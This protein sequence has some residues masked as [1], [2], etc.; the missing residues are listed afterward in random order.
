MK[1][2]TVER[3]RE[4]DQ[5]LA[6]ALER[7][8]EER[9]EWVR[10]ACGEDTA[11]GEAVIRLLRFDEAAERHLGENVT[12]FAQPL[13]P[14]LRDQLAA[15]EEDLAPGTRVGRYRII[16]RIG[17]GGMG[18]VYLA[19]RADD[20]RQR[21]ALKLVKRGM[22][23]DEI[24]SRFRH[25]RQILAR[26]DH[27]NIARLLDGGA[28]EDGR[29]YLVVA[30]VEGEPIDAYCDARRLSVDERLGLFEHVCEA[31]RYAHASLV[32]HRDLKP[33]NIL[34]TESGEV[35]LLDFGIAKLLE[36]DDDA[37]A[38]LTRTGMHRLTPA[39]AAPEQIRGEPVTTA[40]DVYALGV[41]LHELLV[42]R[43]PSATPTRGDAIATIR[44]DRPSGTALTRGLETADLQRILGARSTTLARLRRHLSG[45]LD[46][47]LLTA[48][49][50]EPERRYSSA[51]ALLEDV[52]RHRAHLPIRARRDSLSYRAQAFVRRHRFGVS[53]GAGALV[54]LLGFAVAMTLQQRAT[55]RE[56][57]RARIEAA[58]ATQVAGF[59]EELFGTADPFADERL[60]TLRVRDILARG[61]ERV[62]SDLADQ[63]QV[64]AQLLHV[65]GRVYYAIGYFDE[66]ATNLR[67]SVSLREQ[68]VGVASLETA[69]SLFDLATVRSDQ[70]EVAEAVS[71]A[72]RALAIREALLPPDHADVAA[73]RTQLA[74]DLAAEGAF[75]E[76]ERHFEAA[77]A[78]L[79]APDE[80]D[81]P[82]LASALS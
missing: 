5:L 37:S 72:R 55:A 62:R 35:K 50:S 32:V 56:R 11:L 77:M 8:P 27:P 3:W 48:L 52:R 70:G 79:R 44:T 58:K 13:L 29:P 81:R 59:L 41:L 17:R 61:A 4:I 9:L 76:A 82:T 49:H 75:D 54:L 20:Y 30:Y 46:T 66:A 80:P 39:Y 36:D 78:T 68:H 69:A 18:T 31:V 14:E 22:D 6:E 24:L 34:V 2:L 19:E 21:V 10:V 7:E 47:I 71:L 74:S 28:A 60:D 42:G 65:I 73:S 64:R 1:N 15:A 67:E 53:V 57:D 51:E 25:E 23:T 40:A 45:D 63:P 16:E 43:R 12:D 26:L 33:S 38:P